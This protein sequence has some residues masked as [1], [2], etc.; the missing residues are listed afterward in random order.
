LGAAVVVVVVVNIVTARIGM[1]SPM[2]ADIEKMAVAAA[3]DVVVVGT[4]ALEAVMSMADVDT[5]AVVVGTVPAAEV[6]PFET[7]GME[8]AKADLNIGLGRT[9]AAVAVVGGCQIEAAA[10]AAAWIGN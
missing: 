10:A 3:V 2:A 6:V 4:V 7:A 9:T 1:Q 8:I 5:A